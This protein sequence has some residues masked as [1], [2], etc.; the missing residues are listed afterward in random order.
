[1]AFMIFIH[2]FACR[3]YYI[4]CFFPSFLDF[5]CQLVSFDLTFIRIFGKILRLVSLECLEALLVGQQTF[6]PIFKGGI[7]L[8]FAKVI[9][10]ATYLG[11]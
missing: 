2:C 5:Q 10:L 3:P 6:L 1:M 8:V 11:S 7:G 9:T 4:L